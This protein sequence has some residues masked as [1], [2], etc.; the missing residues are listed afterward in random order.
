MHG[1]PTELGAY[2][3]D[4]RRRTGGDT[5]QQVEATKTRRETIPDKVKMFVWQRDKGQCVKCGSN[6]RLEFDHIIPIAKGG[7][8]TARNLQ[9]LCEQCNRSKGGRIA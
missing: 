1:E 2:L 6:E 3:L 4:Y 9:L 5:A 7:S 8:N